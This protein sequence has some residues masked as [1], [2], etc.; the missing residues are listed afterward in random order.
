MF[1]TRPVHRGS[2]VLETL[3]LLGWRPSLQDRLPGIVRME[4]M[5]CK[6]LLVD[7]ENRIWDLTR[8]DYSDKITIMMN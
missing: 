1:L 7:L 8:F 6:F 2:I 3:I 5:L 4:W